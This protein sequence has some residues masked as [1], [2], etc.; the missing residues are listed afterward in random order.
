[1]GKG[2]RLKAERATRA[3]ELIRDI[4]VVDACEI[5]YAGNGILTIRGGTDEE[6][7]VPIA[8]PS[9]VLPDLLD[10]LQTA[11]LDAEEQY[12]KIIVP[13]ARSVP[14]AYQN[15]DAVVELVHS[16][17]LQE[18]WNAFANC[19]DAEP[20]QLYLVT[21]AGHVGL[22]VDPPFTL[23]PTVAIFDPLQLRRL[24]P[25]LRQAAAQARHSAPTGVSKAAVIA[26]VAHLATRAWTDL[27]RADPTRE[28]AET[29]MH[30]RHREFLARSP[31]MRSEDNTISLDDSAE[32]AQP[33]Q[34]R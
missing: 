15:Q 14:D 1:M 23:R 11:S 16:R 5:E 20:E 26:A 24:D 2:K 31:F 30:G 19:V 22:V 3:G 6:P 21:Q 33:H 17:V 32:H 8:L 12:W 10:T 34:H 29:E 9:Q 25:A 27:R 13:L 7:P 4:V 18:N 28:Q